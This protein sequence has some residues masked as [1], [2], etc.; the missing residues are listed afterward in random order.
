MRKLP[1]EDVITLLDNVLTKRGWTQ[2]RLAKELDI[3]SNTISRW[4]AGKGIH[5]IHYQALLKLLDKPAEVRET[6]VSKINPRASI[7][8]SVTIP[9]SS[10]KISLDKNGDINIQGVILAMLNEEDK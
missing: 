10:L 3:V 9:R 2:D 8:F 4:R 6:S 5:K 7:P 1:S